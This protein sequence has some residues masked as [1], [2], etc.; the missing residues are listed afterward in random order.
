MLGLTACKSSQSSET[1]GQNNTIAPTQSQEATADNANTPT[2][3]VT[4]S[5]ITNTPTSEPTVINTPTSEPTV[6]NT[7][8]PEPTATN[9][10]TTEPAVTEV[11]T[12]KPTATN[13]P[14]PKPKATNTPT[15]KPKAT[16]TPTPKPTQKP[17]IVMGSEKE[18]MRML[19]LV[20][21]ERA[22]V[23]LPALSYY[24]D[25][26]PVVD[27]RAKD[28]TESFSHV[29][30]NGQSCFSLVDEAGI[31]EDQLFENIIHGDDTPEDA[32]F[33]WMLE[34]NHKAAILDDY[35]THMA[36]GV[37]TYNGEKYWVQMFIHPAD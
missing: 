37:V 3:T 29:R 1:T 28:L 25:L 11:S 36:V 32:M 27:Q 9:T 14:T 18:R 5:A 12:P 30:P 10:P 33:W 23:G 15:S 26:Q 21:E 2:E 7:P 35:V 34:P 24:N 4:A 19:E 16:N 17:Q 13:T 20:N 8:I 22:K 31:E 6:T